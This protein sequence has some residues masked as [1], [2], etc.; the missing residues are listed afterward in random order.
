MDLPTKFARTSLLRERHPVESVSRANIVGKRRHGLS[1][2]FDEKIGE[3]LAFLPQNSKKE[4]QG[5]KS[6]LFR[7]ERPT[8][9][10]CVVC[11]QIIACRT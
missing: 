10:G 9:K 3:R 6:E 7:I 11:R 1:S 5:F 8:L 2:A 4:Y